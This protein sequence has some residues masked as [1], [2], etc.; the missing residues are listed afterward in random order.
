MKKKKRLVTGFIIFGLLSSG[1]PPLSVNATESEDECIEASSEDIL[2]SGTEPTS[3]EPFGNAGDFNSE[4][5]KEMEGTRD[6][7][8]V[9]DSNG[10]RYYITDTVY[11]TGWK[12]IGDYW[13]YFN[14][15]TGYMH[16]GW[17][18]Y[19][20]YWYYL[21]LSGHMHRGWLLNNG[22]WYFFESSGHMHIGW[23]LNNGHKY[24]LESTGHMHTGWLSDNGHWYYF[25][26]NSNASDY[27]QMVTG[28]RWITVSGVRHKYYF[29]ADGEM[30]TGWNTINEYSFYFNEIGELEET[31]RRAIIISDDYYSSSLDTN[32][33]NNCLTHL[34]FKG[35]SVETP[36][37]L[38]GPSVANF[39][40][41]LADVMSDA[42]ESDVTYLCITCQG[43]ENGS[44]M[45]SPAT[46][47]DGG[48]LRHE[49][50]KYEGKVILFLSFDYSGLII[51]ENEPDRSGNGLMAARESE[52][53][54]LSAFIDNSRSGE[55]L[56]DKYVVICSCNEEEE[57]VTHTYNE[58]PSLSYGCANYCW[59][60]GGG[61][62]PLYL[63]YL[64][65]LYADSNSNS[66][67]SL[68]ELSTYS[69][70]IANHQHVVVA[71]ADDYFTIFARTS[72]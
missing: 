71:S 30:Q 66:I 14:P 31:T 10:W 7:G 4:N 72:E 26:V 64:S 16:T 21:E 32:G 56:D 15:S 17:L 11:A 28:W 61:W 67:V 9:H 35:A 29:N 8:W 5:G 37:I 44:I 58:N 50:D 34:Q 38:N 22:Y 62:D 69:A 36:H 60:T 6:S 45:I 39:V 27:G 42:E 18:S 20:G 33:W 54:F 70:S 40:N 12:K 59:M 51:Q 2:G 23:L 65:T 41:E 49:L 52:E 55:L 47:I 1:L 46:K 48:A 68:D 3:D 57:L 24:Y 19:N 53:E 25:E 63:G 13:Y 43:L